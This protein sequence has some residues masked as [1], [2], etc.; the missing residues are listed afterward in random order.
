MP[1][2]RIAVVASVLALL[3]LPLMTGAARA[4]VDPNVGVAA[5]AFSGDLD[6]FYTGID[7]RLY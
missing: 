7:E 5:T 6:V 3:A 4:A 2:W 1:R